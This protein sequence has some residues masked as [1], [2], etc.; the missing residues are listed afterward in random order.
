M[1][2]DPVDDGQYFFMLTVGIDQLLHSYPDDAD[3]P[4]PPVYAVA[5]TG[6]GVTGEGG[7]GGTRQTFGLG[8]IQG[9]N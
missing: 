5:S 9:E 8:H 6:S 1:A 7:K 4:Q 3:T 2:Y